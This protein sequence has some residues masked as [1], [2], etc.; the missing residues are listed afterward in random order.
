MRSIS[1][2][3]TPGGL[4]SK[5]LILVGGVNFFACRKFLVLLL[6]QKRSA[7]HGVRKR[8]D[9]ETKRSDLVGTV[10]FVWA[11]DHG[12]LSSAEALLIRSG[13]F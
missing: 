4:R 3:A 6:T 7:F 5:V 1:A 9:D 13:F 11:T 10:V 8:S 2:G 12:S